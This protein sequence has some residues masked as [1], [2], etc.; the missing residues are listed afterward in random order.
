MGGE[1]VVGEGGAAQFVT[2]VEVA[3]QFSVP[4]AGDEFAALAAEVFIEVTEFHKS[5]EW[6]VTGLV[7][8][9][10]RGEVKRVVVSA[11]R[12]VAAWAADGQPVVEGD[13]VQRN[14]RSAIDL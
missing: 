4:P 13:F 7:A 9:G 10:E 6:R 5:G 14:W 1:E 12:I 3:N 2:A 11:P 8:G